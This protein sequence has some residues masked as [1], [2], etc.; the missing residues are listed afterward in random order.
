MK[1]FVL[2]ITICL[3]SIKL[4]NAQAD[5]V[6]RLTTI[7][8]GTVD[9]YFN[10]ENKINNGFELTNFTRFRVYFVATDN[11]GNPT[12]AA[13]RLLVRSNTAQI[14]GDAG[15]TLDL[16]TVQIFADSG[17][18]GTDQG[19]VSLAGTDVLLVDAG[20]NPA[21]TID[22]TISYRCGMDA[23]YPIAGQTPDHYYVDLIFTLEL[24]P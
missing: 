21:N 24:I 11:L 20:V 22:V 15:N 8:S 12:A 23:T 7:A 2:I 1:R 16:R 19:W 4:I 5:T 17:G 14:D 18:N 3:I 9:F 13:W 6:A 10:S